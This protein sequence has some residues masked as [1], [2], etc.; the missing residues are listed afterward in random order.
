MNLTKA[1]IRNQRSDIK[2]PHLT[3]NKNQMSP[4]SQ[5]P[6]YTGA[7]LRLW[8]VD[9]QRHEALQEQKAQASQGLVH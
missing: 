8:V 2:P 5:G 4:C 7:G 6:S 1:E 3:K 9:L